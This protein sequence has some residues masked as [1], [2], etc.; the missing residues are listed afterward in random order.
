[1]NRHASIDPV[2]ELKANV[3][4]PFERASA[5]PRSVYT[6]EA[7]LKRELEDLFAREWYCVG[8]VDQF[9]TPGDYVATELAGRPILVIRDKGGALRALSNVCRHRMS[10]LLHGSGNA[11]S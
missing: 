6:S 1:M 4:V 7:F 2:A 3:A 10:T 5:M 8:R 11:Q 9:Q